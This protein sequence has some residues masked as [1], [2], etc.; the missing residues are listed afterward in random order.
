[1]EI[2]Y[3]SCNFCVDVLYSQ[4]YIPYFPKKKAINPTYMRGNKIR[5]DISMKKLRS[6][7][8]K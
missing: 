8:V 2:K 4:L 5:E 6:F 7:F 3:A 1:M